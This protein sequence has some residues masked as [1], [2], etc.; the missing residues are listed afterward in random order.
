MND[1]EEVRRYY[2]AILPYYDESLTDRGDLPFWE[3]I[4][5]RWKPKRILEL[6][7]G[8]GRVTEVLDRHADVTAADLLVEMLRLACRRAPAAKFV[9]ADLRQFAFA[10]RF[11]LIV[12]A[13]DPMAHLLSIDDR[14]KALRLIADH[15]TPDGRVVIE[16]LYRREAGDS[17]KRRGSLIVDESWKTTDDPSVWSAHYRYEK[18][19]AVLEVRS[20]LRSWSASDLE[21]LAT[22]GLDVESMWGD[23]DE[24]PFA[25]ATSNRM[26]IAA[27]PTR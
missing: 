3:A 8:T 26:I 23:F 11:D 22:C 1:S 5:T 24:R 4:G 12:L 18:G 7:C 20:V 14:A 15:L 17:Q 6:G 16:G 27:K 10:R 9:A 19:G 2:E 21:L 13:D 25:A